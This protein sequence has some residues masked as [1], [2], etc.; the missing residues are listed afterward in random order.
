MDQ[1][2]SGQFGEVYSAI[3]SFRD[4]RMQL[5]VKILKPSATEADKLR[6]L[7]E[8]AIMGQFRH[9][10]IIKLHGVVTMGEP[11]SFANNHEDMDLFGLF[12]AISCGRVVRQ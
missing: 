4:H 12:C 3:W 6:F 10:H 11:V 1:L 8:A 7:Q 9:P 2:G 5:A